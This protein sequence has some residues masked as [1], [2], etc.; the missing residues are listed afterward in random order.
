MQ[1]L[2]DG[3]MN[4]VKETVYAPAVISLPLIPLSMFLDGKS[5]T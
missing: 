2:V 4:I 3:T 1:V 5:N